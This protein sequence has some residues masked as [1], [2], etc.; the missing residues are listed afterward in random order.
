MYIPN[1]R[2][3]VSRLSVRLDPDVVSG[4]KAAAR[5]LGISANG[6]AVMALLDAGDAMKK[7][8]LRDSGKRRVSVPLRVPEKVRA[9]LERLAAETGRSMSNVIEVSL[10]T[11]LK[12]PPK[13][14]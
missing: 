1:P 8:A 9:S 10:R 3:N 11:K 12:R 14:R 7:P 4:L 13:A 5:D 2:D 6:F